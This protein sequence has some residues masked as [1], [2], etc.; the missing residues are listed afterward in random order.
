MARRGLGRG[1]DALLTSTDVGADRLSEVPVDAI[2]PN[3]YQPRRGSETEDLEELTA[4][5]RAHGL[6]QPLV[7]RSDGDAY[8]IIAG[9]RRWR[10]ARAAGMKRVPVVVR[11]AGPREMLALAIVENVQRSDLDPIES[12]LAYRQLIDEFGL[13]QSEVAEL[14]GKSRV[15][16]ANSVR[17][18]GLSEAVRDLLSEGA[19]SEGH[20]RALL[21]VADHDA[22]L[23]LAKRALDGNWT[24]R[25]IEDEIRGPRPPSKR[26]KR[27]RSGRAVDPDTAAAIAELEAAL[28]T[29][30]DI[31]RRG[32]SGRLVIHYYSEE[33]LAA[34]FDRLVDRS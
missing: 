13:T 12:A 8:Q 2:E 22:Q 14:V 1:L 4:S 30:V 15:A 20:G 19:L 31:Q 5:I 25:R 24:V 29:R 28:G 32:T 21:A 3:P 26:K 11:D 10:A 33:E 6:I 18:L 17:L 23:E 34:L 7:V 16:I 9:E 27:P